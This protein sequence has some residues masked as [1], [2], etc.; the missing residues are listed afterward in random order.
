MID[1]SSFALSVANL[2]FLALVIIQGMVLTC[3]FSLPL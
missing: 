1:V 2:Y 3:P